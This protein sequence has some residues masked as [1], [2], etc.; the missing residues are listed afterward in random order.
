M[1]STDRKRAIIGGVD[2][3]WEEIPNN[4]PGPAL[5]ASCIPASAPS[6]TPDS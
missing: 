1:A 2:T 6:G 5:L 3:D 4:H